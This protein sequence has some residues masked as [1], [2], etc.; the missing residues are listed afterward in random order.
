MSAG[1][2]K[3]WIT[4]LICLLCKKDKRMM[5]E[6]SRFYRCFYDTTKKISMFRS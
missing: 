5:Y 3:H 2:A 1:Q 4:P 6:T